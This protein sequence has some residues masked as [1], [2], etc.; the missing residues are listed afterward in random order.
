MLEEFSRFYPICFM[1]QT[2]HHSLAAG[3]LIHVCICVLGCMDSSFNAH[4]GY[5]ESVSLCLI[6]IFYTITSHF[7]AFCYIPALL[8]LLV[9]L[10]FIEYN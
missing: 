10:L 5:L 9:K 8:S 4:V 6:T 1:M 7:V 2:F 3:L